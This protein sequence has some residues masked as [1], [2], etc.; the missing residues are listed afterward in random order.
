MDQV[1]REEAIEAASK[2]YRRD[3]KAFRKHN[4]E[5]PRRM[6]KTWKEKWLATRLLTNFT[7]ALYIF[8]D[9]FAIKGARRACS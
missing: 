4:N 8:L 5:V 1:D 2:N 6:C 9:V 7:H 3:V